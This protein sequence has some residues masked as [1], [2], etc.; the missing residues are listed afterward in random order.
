MGNVSDLRLVAEAQLFS[1]CASHHDVGIPLTY[2]PTVTIYGR[3]AEVISAWLDWLR[4]FTERNSQ[5]YLQVA[6][7]LAF[8]IFAHPGHVCAAF[9]TDGAV[10]TPLFK[11]YIYP[12]L[13][14]TH[15]IVSLN[16]EMTMVG[17]MKS[18]GFADEE[19]TTF[20]SQ[21]AMVP[22]SKHKMDEYDDTVR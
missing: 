19:D 15:S 17:G 13:W 6:Q 5:H 1:A 18:Q 4:P 2:A 8:N 22:Q 12:T 20:Y 16:M 3:K 11:M 10:A 9:C 14:T 21:E 7:S